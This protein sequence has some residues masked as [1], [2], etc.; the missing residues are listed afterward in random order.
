MRLHSILT[1]LA[2][3]HPYGAKVGVLSIALAVGLLIGA[4]SAGAQP[5]PRYKVPADSEI[6]IL[7]MR[8]RPTELGE[9]ATQELSVFADGRCRLRRPAM[10]RGS[11]EHAWTIP[12]SEVRAL[13][14]K[15]LDAG[16]ADMDAKGHRKNLRARAAAAASG[17]QHYRFDDDTVEFDIRVDAYRAPGR[18]KHRAVR[19]SVE[20]RGLRTDRAR[21]PDDVPVRLLAEL[22]D[23]LEALG[24]TH[25]PLDP[26]P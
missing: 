7:V 17:V 18:G 2:A 13:L 20:W 10:M 22:R 6:P 21:H 19:R 15:A 26:Q 16:L 23:E 9:A 25:A 4:A 14:G 3:F 11:G 12:T 24:R 5:A 8:Q 1:H